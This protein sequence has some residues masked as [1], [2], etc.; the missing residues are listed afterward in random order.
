MFC[1][2]GLLLELTSS[3]VIYPSSS[4][5]HSMVWEL[6]FT[7]D[8]CKSGILYKNLV[9]TLFLAP[10]YLCTIPGLKVRNPFL[11]EETNVL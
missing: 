5:V 9:L 8:I 3:E 2:Q 11:L 4:I 6:E 7:V 1:Q 10:L